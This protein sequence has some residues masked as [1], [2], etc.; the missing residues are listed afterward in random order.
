MPHLVHCA[1]PLFCL[2]F[3]SPRSSDLEQGGGLAIESKVQAIGHSAAWIRVGHE[4][5]PGQ[6]A[7]QRGVASL[8]IVHS[9]GVS[10]WADQPQPVED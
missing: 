1:L 2:A 9:R 10:H 8:Q 3:L 4:L 5:P 7:L 6:A